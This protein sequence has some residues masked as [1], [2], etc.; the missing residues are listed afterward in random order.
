MTPSDQLCHS[1]HA[2]LCEQTCLAQKL[3]ARYFRKSRVKHL[4]PRLFS[5]WPSPQLPW[6]ACLMSGGRQQCF[7]CRCCPPRDLC[8]ASPTRESA[9][10][11]VVA[12]AVSRRSRPRR[13]RSSLGTPTLLAERPAQASAGLVLKAVRDE[14]R[15]HAPRPDRDAGDRPWLV[16]PS[17]PGKEVAFSGSRARTALVHRR[18]PQPLVLRLPACVNVRE[19]AHA[20]RDASRGSQCQGEWGRHGSERKADG[21][22]TQSNTQPSIQPIVGKRPWKAAGSSRDGTRQPASAQVNTVSYQDLHRKN[23]PR[24]WS[25]ELLKDMLTSRRAMA[26][27]SETMAL[28]SETLT[29]KS[30][31]RFESMRTGRHRAASVQMPRE[32]K[33][34]GAAIVA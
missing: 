32:E 29:L 19:R 22:A 6:Q 2:S 7:Y 24:L 5:T 33:I 34:S 26:L 10:W 4:L 25:F 23:E 28:E 13:H 8:V 9:P 3:V 17:P 31:A 15:R 14:A 20:R 30:V 11:I 18:C 16:E 12:P 27:E 1:T 21:P